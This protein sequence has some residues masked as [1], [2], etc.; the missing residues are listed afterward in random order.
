MYKIGLR[1]RLLK[2]RLNM[3]NKPTKIYQVIENKKALDK[4]LEWM[5]EKKFNISDTKLEILIE[6]AVNCL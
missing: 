5:K 1:K 3:L 6:S 2:E 4:S